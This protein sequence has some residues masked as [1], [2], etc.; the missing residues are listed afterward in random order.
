[1]GWSIQ[2]E[3]SDPAQTGCIATQDMRTQPHFTPWPHSHLGA[4]FFAL[5]LATAGAMEAEDTWETGSGHLAGKDLL[6]T[7]T[8]HYCQSMDR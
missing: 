2:E 5:V 7:S 4:L 8:I 3:D 6:Q 1:M